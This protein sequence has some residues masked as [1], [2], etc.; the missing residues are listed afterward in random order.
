MKIGILLT[1]HVMDK[2]RIKHG[3]MDDFYLYIFDQVDSSIS[4]EILM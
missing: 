2:L 1:D 4:L 3:D